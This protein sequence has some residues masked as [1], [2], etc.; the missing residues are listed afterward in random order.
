MV[1]RDAMCTNWQ[2]RRRQYVWVYGR[3]LQQHELVKTSHYTYSKALTMA[4][5]VHD[6]AR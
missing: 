2:E 4:G 1:R 5:F 3:G 6:A